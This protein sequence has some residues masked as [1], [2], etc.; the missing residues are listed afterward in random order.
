MS[1][2]AKPQNSIQQG[3]LVSSTRLDKARLENFSDEMSL[4]DSEPGLGNQIM[5]RLLSSRVIQAKL[6]V[7]QPGDEYEQEAD[8]VAEK[9]VGGSKHL[10]TFTVIDNSREINSI[11]SSSGETLTSFD[12]QLLSN[13]GTG[14]T[15]D[16]LVK[17]PFEQALGV[18]FSPVRVHT[19]S[20]ANELAQR[21]DALAITYGK[22]IFFRKGTYDPNSQYGLF[23]IAHELTH[24]VQQQSSGIETPSY[25]LAEAVRDHGRLIETMHPLS[26]TF[27]Q[28]LSLARHARSQPILPEK[29][30]NSGTIYVMRQTVPAD[31]TESPCPEPSTTRWGKTV[32]PVESLAVWV[33]VRK[34]A[35]DQY[36]VPKWQQYQNNAAT[37]ASSRVA[38]LFAP[39]EDDLK[40]DKTFAVVAGIGAKGW[41][42]A[43]GAAVG[44]VPGAVGGTILGNAAGEVLQHVLADNT[45]AGVKAKAAAGAKAVTRKATAIETEFQFIRNEAL[46][47]LNAL[48]NSWWNVQQFEEGMDDLAQAQDKAWYWLD[49]LWGQ[50]DPLGME[51]ILN[52]E[53][54]LVG[55]QIFG[56]LY[57]VWEELER[58][59]KE[60]RR[61]TL[62]EGGALT[63]GLLGLGLGPIGALVGAAGGYAAGAIINELYE[64]SGLPEMES[65]ERFEK[66][67]LGIEEQPRKGEES[68]RE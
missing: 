5:Q 36:I 34:V 8:R 56:V 65:K 25:V 4:Q 32:K 42:A 39:Y 18:D 28:P 1:I 23:L 3:H 57:P 63:G 41:G 58:L 51:Q 49:S 12:E 2:F 13:S 48:F 50:K 38:N 45:V 21:A 66:A 33:E 17:E 27:S 6:T 22:D 43:V 16:T 30:L 62:Y 60:R 26:M 68:E 9:I 15:L 29:L 20:R 40:S 37:M 53:L 11:I 52:D 46:F 54:S 10:P 14:T 59:K 31:R 44:G 24:I 19:D 35:N 47:H 7:S 61:K 64:L 67:L 55:P